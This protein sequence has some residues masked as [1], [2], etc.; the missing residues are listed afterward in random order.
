M[1]FIH[2]DSWPFQTTKWDKRGER[3]RKLILH[4]EW[5]SFYI[6]QSTKHL[7][8]SYNTLNKSSSSGVRCSEFKFHVYHWLS[9]RRLR[10]ISSLCLRLLL[11]FWQLPWN[12]SILLLALSEVK[13]NPRADKN[14]KSEA[15]LINILNVN[16][17]NTSNKRQVIRM[18]KKAT[19]NYVLTTKGSL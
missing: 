14:G 13:S 16:G 7:L 9:C 5:I 4:D 17:L 19:S 1:S 6:Y 10:W 2:N 15:T 18:D 8:G 3:L 11:S 12:K